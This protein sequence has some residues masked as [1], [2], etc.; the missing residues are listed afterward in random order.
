MHKIILLFFVGEL[1]NLIRYFLLYTN[2]LFVYSIIFSFFQ[3]VFITSA[4]YLLLL[5]IFKKLKNR[6]ILLLV[7]VLK[8]CV[9]FI[10]YCYEILEAFIKGGVIFE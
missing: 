10:L 3:G 1:F 6:K 7:L 9:F 8:S 5:K 2:D 4:E